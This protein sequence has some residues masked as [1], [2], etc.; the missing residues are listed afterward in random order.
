MQV[1]NYVT[2]QNAINVTLIGE[3]HCT[4]SVNDQCSALLL[5]EVENKTCTNLIHCQHPLDSI[6][7]QYTVLGQCHYIH[8]HFSITRET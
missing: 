7:V 8:S 4:I 1:D 5:P 3:Y 6:L 2:I